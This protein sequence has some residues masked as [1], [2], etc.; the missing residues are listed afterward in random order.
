MK[1]NKSYLRNIIWL[2]FDVLL[3]FFLSFGMSA[4][5][6]RYF[7]VEL[8]GLYSY[9][10]AIFSIFILVS[11]LGM[12]GIVVRELVL[13]SKHEEVL[14][15]AFFLQRAGAFVLSIFLVIWIFVSEDKGRDFYIIF[16]LM[17]PILFLQSANIFKYWFEYKM[18]AKYSVIS[19]N[20]SLV[21]GAV[22]KLVL[23]HYGCGYQYI[24]AVTIIEQVVFILLVR[25]F[26][27][28]KLVGF[29]FKIN[30]N[31][32][33]ELLSKSWPLIIS[34]LAFILF[35]RIDQIMIGEILSMKEVG[36][37]SIVVK[38]I[39]ASFF[40]P[41]ILMSTFFP[42]LVELSEKSPE[43]YDKKMQLL[44]DIVVVIGIFIFIFIFIFGEPLIKYTFGVD[45][46][47]SV[48]QLKI[49]SLVCIFYYLSVVSGKW[50]INAGLQKIAIFR[51][52]IGLIVAIFLNLILIPIYGITGA[53]ISTVIAYIFSS[54]FFDF[55][56]LRTRKVFYQ[57][58]R[59]LFLVGVIG[60]LIEEVV[61]R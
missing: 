6:A 30:I 56:D 23:I 37:F 35:I 9:L 8:F 32:C 2:F 34:G 5:I 14:G 41:V 21:I 61:K 18:E 51:N 15:S 29:K 24:I 11:S 42:A 3:K 10:L 57:K 43:D 16:F 19:Q 25:C 40:I 55:F 4:I 54:Y 26:F 46:I 36:V 20:I 7:G 33:F 38:F 28:R 13:S 58:T 22:L 45:Y 47:D 17:L 31:V 48:V 50:Y 1:F 52:A 59:S 27:Y 12:N 60:R 39:E 53:S 44:Y 49:Y